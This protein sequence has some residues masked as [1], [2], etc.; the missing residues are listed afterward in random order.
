MRGGG[1]GWVDV[2][3]GVVLGAGWNLALDVFHPLTPM[4]LGNRVT[5]LPCHLAMI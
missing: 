1:E 2:G 5:W 3:V 4:S